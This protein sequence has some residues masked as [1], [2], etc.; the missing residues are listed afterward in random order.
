MAESAEHMRYVEQIVSYLETI[1]NCLDELIEADLPN[2]SGRT[3]KVLGIYYP[4]VYYRDNNMIIIG[5]AKTENDIENIH[6][7]S[8][9]TAY[10]EEAKLFQGERHIILACSIFALATMMNFVI[11][12]KHEMDTTGINFHF[13]DSLN[14]ISKI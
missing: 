4:D 8:Q 10:I 6:T 1:P 9:L 12:L 13:L 11:H 5:E 7:K 2:Y 3:S 14:R